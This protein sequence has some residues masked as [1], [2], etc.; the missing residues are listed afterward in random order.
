MREIDCVVQESAP[1][2]VS[3]ERV[4]RL[5]RCGRSICA[6]RLWVEASLDFKHRLQQLFFPEGIAYDRNRF[7]RTTAAALLSTTWRRP[8]VLMKVVSR[9][10]IEPS[11]AVLRIQR[12][13]V[14]RYPRSLRASDR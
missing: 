6:E 3:Q 4:H 1:T 12:E 14:Q 11:F 13:F 8:G 5:L 9:K 10:G 7:N 2:T